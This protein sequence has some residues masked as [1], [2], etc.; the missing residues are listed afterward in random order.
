MA[1][2]LLLGTPEVSV[3]GGSRLLAGARRQTLLGMLALRRNA[4]VGADDL[5]EQVWAGLELRAA[6]RALRNEVERLRDLLWGC[7]AIEAPPGAYR[8]VVAPADLDLDQFGQLMGRARH[9]LAADPAAAAHD[10]DRALDLWR[11]RPFGDLVDTPELLEEQRRL[12]EERLTCRELR[13]EALLAAG[14]PPG[15]LV[16]EL[17]LLTAAW[18]HRERFWTQLLTALWRDGRPTDALAAFERVRTTL[19]DDLDLEPWP[20]LCR[21]RAAIV[22]DAPDPR[23]SS[24]P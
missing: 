8:L 22:D 10:A 19:A 5:A 15:E 13:I 23:R 4:E 17:T 18:P 16:G 12:E 11:G 14:H 2:L 1:R 21:L 7:A 3:D 20:A 9:T 6:R 24:S